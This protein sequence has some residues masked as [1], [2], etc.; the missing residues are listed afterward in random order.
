[1]HRTLLLAA[2]AAAA[3]AALALW[4]DPAPAAS[5]EY[6]V[7]E[8]KDGG[9]IRGIVRLKTDV[10]LPP[11]KITKDNDKGC[12][13]AEQASERLVYDRATKGVGN[14]L[15]RIEK[16]DAGKDWPE[17]MRAE[18]RTCEIDQK[19]C[20]Y[21]P[22]AQWARVGT[23][24]IVLN[25]DRADHNI[26]GYRNSMKDTAFNFSSEPGTKKDDIEQAF[27]EEP[28][29]YIVKCDIHPWMSAYLHVVEHPY[30]DLTS[31]AEAGGRKPGEFVIDQVP[32]GEY[33]LVFW[34]E[35]IRETPSVADGRITAY[36][37]SPD[38]VWKVPVKVAA[39]QTVEVPADQ[40]EIDPAK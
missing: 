6:K 39:G 31:A 17:S 34:K 35:G 40:T 27:L 15:V 20:K 5:K 33:T 19:G 3:F 13:D 4:A 23:Q 32:P 16:I 12:G 9:T 14:V 11:V 1:M 28:A 37:Y 22:H 10:D 25:G 18:D 8:V 21:V 36:T 38:I 7:V 26:H 30:H 2:G 24:L 29:A